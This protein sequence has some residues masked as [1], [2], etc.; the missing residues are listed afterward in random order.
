MRE[1]GRLRIVKTVSYR[2]FNHFEN[3]T[4]Y[5]IRTSFFQERITSFD[6][7]AMVSYTTKYGKDTK[8]FPTLGWMANLCAHIPKQGVNRWIGS[9]D[10]VTLSETSVQLVIITS[11]RNRKLRTRRC[12]T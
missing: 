2:R 9:K 12:Y 5:I 10:Y 8:V 1:G 4:V 3:L 7:Q 11:I 6:Q